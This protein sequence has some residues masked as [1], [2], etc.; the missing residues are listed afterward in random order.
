MN[1]GDSISRNCHAS[2]SRGATPS[3]N[4]ATRH[5]ERACRKLKQTELDPTQTPNSREHKSLFPQTSE[6]FCRQNERP[7]GRTR[8]RWAFRVIRERADSVNPSGFL[9][10]RI[11]VFFLSY[12]GNVNAG[13]DVFH[14]SMQRGGERGGGRR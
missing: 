12:L 9:N 4:A 13:R 1:V 8:R 10:R 3:P 14:K 5:R 6:V 2:I 7:A 11:S